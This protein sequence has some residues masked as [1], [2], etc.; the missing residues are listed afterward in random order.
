M[1]EQRREE[2]RERARSIHEVL[3]NHDHRDGPMDGCLCESLYLEMRDIWYALN[4][5]KQLN[6]EPRAGPRPP[7][8]GDEDH[9]NVDLE[10]WLYRKQHEPDA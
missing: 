9:P 8:T 3:V 2:L 5:G 4:E 1:T 10:N 6:H 7:Y